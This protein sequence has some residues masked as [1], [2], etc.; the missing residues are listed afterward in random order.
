MAAPEKPFDPYHGAFFCRHC[1]ACQVPPRFSN[2]P[3]LLEHL[4][5]EHGVAASD[6]VDGVDI[7]Y[8]WF[9]ALAIREQHEQEREREENAA[10]DRFAAELGTVESVEGFLARCE[11]PA[12]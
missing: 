1:L 5:D 6:A 8:G 4:A 3:L 12:G 9:E 11:P 7:I 10:A 2:R